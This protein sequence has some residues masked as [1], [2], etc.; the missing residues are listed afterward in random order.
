M[1]MR[2]GGREIEAVETQAKG[3]LEFLPNHPGSRRRQMD[4]ERLFITYGQRNLV[5]NFRSMLNLPPAATD[6]LSRLAALA[7]CIVAGAICALMLVRLVWLL[8]PRSTDAAST[9][10]P[11]P[12]QAQPSAATSIAQW[13]LFGNAQTIDLAARAANAPRTALKLVLRRARTI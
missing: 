1:K 3:Q 5:R 7:V 2:P 10:P 11:V 9:Q 13:H 6:R 4:G 12:A 8:I